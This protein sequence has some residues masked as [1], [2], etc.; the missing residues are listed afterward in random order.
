MALFTGLSWGAAPFVVNSV[1]GLVTDSITG[2]MWDQCPYGKSGSTC[3]SGTAFNGNWAS[4][5]TQA[6]LANA[7]NGG[8]GYKGFNDWRLPNKNE[9]ESIVD[10][11]T[12]LPAVDTSAFPGTYIGNVNYWTSTS[13][14]NPDF[15]HYL[16]LGLGSLAF[17]G[18]SEGAFVHLVR[19]G[20]P[21]A[22]YDMLVD[23]TSPSITGVTGPS[24]GSYKA[25]ENLDLIVTFDEAVIVHTTSGTP[26]IAITL[27]SSTVYAIYMSG[28]TSSTLTFRYIVQAGNTDADGIAI[29][30]PLDLHSGTIKDAANNS[31]NLTFTSPTLTSVLV[32]TTAPTKGSPEI[33]VSDTDTS[34]SYTAGDT[35]TLNFSEPVSVSNIAISNSH[36]LGTSPGI[37]PSSGLTSSIVITLGT[38]PSVVSGD[39]FTI[40]SANVADAAGNN[41]ASD[42]VFTLPSLALLPQTITFAPASPVTV[43][44]SDITLSATSTSLLSSF[45]FSTS[46]LGNICTVSVATLHIVGPG[47]CN[48]TAIQAGNGTFASATANA[49]VVINAATTPGV[50]GTAVGQSYSTA[51]TTNLCNPGNASSITSANGQYSWTCTSTNGGAT[52]GTCIATWATAGTGTGTVVVPGTGNNNWRIAS[53]NFTATSGNGAPA[54]PPPSN[55][56]FSHGLA[57]FV[58]TGGDPNTAATIT[59]NYTTAVLDGAVY[60]KYGKSPEGYSCTGVACAQ[61]HWY[62]LP[63]GQ[64]AYSNGRKTITLT[65]TDGQVGDSDNVAGQITDPG[66]PAVLNANAASIPALSE[67]GMIILSALLAVG[68]FGVMRRRQI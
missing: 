66:G 46:S 40:G 28:S 59:L 35:I 18:K 55:Y 10:I 38:S 67:W 54:T 25:G 33:S 50:C 34:H 19:G 63:S 16:N 13:Y 6:K 31:A 32:D 68:T 8:V 9:L 65:I 44:A 7:L 45:T 51:P 17:V 49:S 5:L 42:W 30:S 15:A 64:V 47:T 61:D 36:T 37:V 23:S 24:N 21:L 12:A 62:P 60:M 58:L 2:L 56:A 20:Q 39:T 3:A 14:G 26:R 1:D 52:S 11:T 22:A 57:S 29:A 48:L 41:A 27:G 4:A 53:S 43:G